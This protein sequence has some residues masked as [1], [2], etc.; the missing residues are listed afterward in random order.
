MDYPNFSIVH[1]NVDCNL[2]FNRYV[3]LCANLT[4]IYSSHKL[5]S[6]PT[7]ISVENSTT[8]RKPIKQCPDDNR[9]WNVF[10]LYKHTSTGAQKRLIRCVHLQVQRT[11]EAYKNY[12]VD[13]TK[14]QT[15]LD[16]RMENLLKIWRTH[17][18]VQFTYDSHID[19]YMSSVKSFTNKATPYQITMVK[20][21][22]SDVHC[23]VG[24]FMCTEDQTCLLDIKVCDDKYDCTDE[25]D[26]LECNQPV[27]IHQ[28]S[29]KGVNS[30]LH[31]CYNS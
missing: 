1:A 11:Y 18:G 10:I 29:G 4:H 31:L 22:Q 21:I 7:S 12:C 8:I 13:A 5:I 15:F 28:G 16:L 27:C 30:L 9:A 26:E 24:M 14:T 25:S 3:H 19:P 2:R 23:D 20:T 6:E 17:L